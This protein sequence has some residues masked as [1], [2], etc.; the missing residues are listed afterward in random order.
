[1]CLEK[2]SDFDRLNQTAEDVD[3]MRRKPSRVTQE[4]KAYVGWCVRKNVR[5]RHSAVKERREGAVN[6]S[7]VSIG[8]LGGVQSLSRSFRVGSSMKELSLRGC[9]LTHDICVELLK[10][11]AVGPGHVPAASHG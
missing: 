3:V 8:G 11:I 5:P 4:A 9:L 7:R 2:R 1:M 6:M 10:G